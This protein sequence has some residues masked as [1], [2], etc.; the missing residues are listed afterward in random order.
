MADATQ[1]ADEQKYF[2]HAAEWRERSR[3]TLIAALENT[4]GPKDAAGMKRKIDEILAKLGGPDEAV[5]IGRFDTE[6]ETLYVGKRRI[7]DGELNNVFERVT[8]AMQLAAV[9]ALAGLAREPVPVEVLAAYGL[10]SLAFG[11][12]Y[13]LPKPFD[14][15]LRERVA[16]AVAAAARAEAD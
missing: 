9:H 6:S 5:A 10:S 3:E 13:I 7:S 14:P 4:A 16:G 1:I 12:E 11:R 2:D 15:R 8:P